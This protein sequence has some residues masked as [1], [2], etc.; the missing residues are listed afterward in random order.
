MCSAPAPEGQ[1]HLAKLKFLRVNVKIW[2]GGL[3]LDYSHLFL[4]TYCVFGFFVL[5]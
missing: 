3:L 2:R 4:L 1:S 5:H